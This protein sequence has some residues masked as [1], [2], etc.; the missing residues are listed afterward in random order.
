MHCPDVKGRGM[1]RGI[2]LQQRP[3][4]AGRKPTTRQ[5]VAG[6]SVERLVGRLGHLV[7]I[8]P[9][10]GAQMPP[11]YRM[12]RVT[13]PPFVPGGRRQRPGKMTVWGEGPAQ[14]GY[15]QSLAW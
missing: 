8:E 9:A 7:Q 2:E 5:L 4:G 6:A 1:Q 12:E 13:W 11:L 15:Q 10:A 14:A 3:R